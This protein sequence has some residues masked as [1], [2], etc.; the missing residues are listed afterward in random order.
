M[1][2]VSKKLLILQRIYFSFFSNSVL[3]ISKHLICLKGSYH[4][5]LFSKHLSLNLK[6]GQNPQ[7][8]TIDFQYKNKPLKIEFLLTY[9]LRILCK[10]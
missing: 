9:F 5:F 1:F 2:T 7:K 10:F 3:S 6:S 4:Q 8:S